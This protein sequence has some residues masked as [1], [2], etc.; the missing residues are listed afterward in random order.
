MFFEQKTKINVP[1]EGD[2]Q[3]YGTYVI[4]DGDYLYA[5]CD[6]VIVSSEK[7]I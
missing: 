7:L 5:D 4:N 2:V 3:F 6:G 1:K